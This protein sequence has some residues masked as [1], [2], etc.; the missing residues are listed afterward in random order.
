[1]STKIFEDAD[2]FARHNWAE[3]KEAPHMKDCAHCGA[4][5]VIKDK[6][7]NGSGPYVVM[8]PWCGI[9]TKQ[10]TCFPVVA[11]AWNAMVKKPCRKADEE[12]AAIDQTKPLS[13]ADE[14]EKYGLVGGRR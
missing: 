9:Q 4:R 2:E 13:L 14:A 5:P 7:I 8:C 10:S 12:T 1:M 6:G 3:P 11:D